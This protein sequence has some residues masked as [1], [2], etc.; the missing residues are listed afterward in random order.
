MGKPTFPSKDELDQLE[1]IQAIMNCHNEHSMPGLSKL[2]RLA[3]L[4]YRLLHLQV[5]AMDTVCQLE[6][7]HAWLQQIAV[8]NFVVSLACLL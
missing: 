7:H 5:A 6:M 2:Q 8:V 4:C 3:F 1:K